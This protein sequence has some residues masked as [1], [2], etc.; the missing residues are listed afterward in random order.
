MHA[1]EA[2]LER[3]IDRFEEVEARLGSAAD[4]D[5][6]VRLSREH[7]ELRPVADKARELKAARAELDDLE[8]MMEGDDKDMAEMAR[9][10][11]YAL[12]DYAGK[13]RHMHRTTALGEIPV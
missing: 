7:A 3:V 4:G 5:E 2:R 10:E 9:E 6:I 11:Y 1:P 13:R 12:N 8:E